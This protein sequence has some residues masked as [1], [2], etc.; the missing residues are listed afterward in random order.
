M[1]PHIALLLCHAKITNVSKELCKKSFLPL[2]T[3]K[4]Q[5]GKHI[6]ILTDF[7][8]PGLITPYARQIVFHLYTF[9]HF[10]SGQKV[11]KNQS[12]PH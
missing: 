8:S 6:I 5:R 4:L 7:A 11:S 3:A 1:K 12:K 10:N 9:T 2:L